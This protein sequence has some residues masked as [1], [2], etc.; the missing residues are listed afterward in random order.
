MFLKLSS[1]FE[2]IE[3]LNIKTKYTM[4]KFPCKPLLPNMERTEN[5]RNYN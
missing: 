2:H 5:T 3:L 1:N 4:I